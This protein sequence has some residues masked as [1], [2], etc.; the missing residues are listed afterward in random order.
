MRTKRELMTEILE[1]AVIESV[2]SDCEVV[3]YDV[4]VHGEMHRLQVITG[5]FFVEFHHLEDGE[6]NYNCPHLVYTFDPWEIEEA[7]D[8][9][10]MMDGETGELHVDESK[11][12][13]GADEEENCELEA[14]ADEEQSKLTIA[15][16]EA[17]KEAKIEVLTKLKASYVDSHNEYSEADDDAYRAVIGMTIY[18]K[19]IQSIE[20]MLEELN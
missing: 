17:K 6:Y 1:T 7:L 4:E 2:K 10:F 19:C 14:K 5:Q 12:E 20:K 18:G 9:F 8:T 16:E 13:L 11:I 15:V 3:H